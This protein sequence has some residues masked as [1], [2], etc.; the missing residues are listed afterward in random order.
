MSDDEN[1]APYAD[2]LADDQ[3]PTF[4]FRVLASVGG[5]GAMHVEQS[6]EGDVPAYL[7][8]GVIFAATIDRFHQFLHEHEDDVE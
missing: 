7:A 1:W 2:L 8:I 4:G 5:D 3:L 6:V